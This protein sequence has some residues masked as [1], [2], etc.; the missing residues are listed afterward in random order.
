MGFLG[1]LL[2]WGSYSLDKWKYLV[3]PAVMDGKWIKGLK[4]RGVLR[5]EVK[6]SRSKKRQIE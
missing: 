2:V 4:R 1:L 5:E 3:K 6:I